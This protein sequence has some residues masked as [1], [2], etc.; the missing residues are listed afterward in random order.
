MKFIKFPLLFT[1]VLFISWSMVKGYE[2][3]NWEFWIAFL[4]GLF[5]LMIYNYLQDAKSGK[6]ESK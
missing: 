2:T 6:E 3:M 1:G 4:L 5:S